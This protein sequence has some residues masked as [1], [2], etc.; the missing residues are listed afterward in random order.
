MRSVLQFILQHLTM[1]DLTAFARSATTVFTSAV[2]GA[3]IL[4]FV[5]LRLRNRRLKVRTV[6]LAKLRE[7]VRH[8][9]G[10]PISIR[11]AV[12]NILRGANAYHV[13]VPGMLPESSATTVCIH[14]RQTLPEGYYRLECRPDSVM[15][16]L[17]EAD[18][19]TNTAFAVAMFTAKS[20]DR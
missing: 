9:A 1:I 12:M 18:R 10:T 2:S 19:K 11:P 16:T 15:F 5:Q 7:H 20:A 14:S 8:H 17:L 13:E 3:G 6:E 4:R